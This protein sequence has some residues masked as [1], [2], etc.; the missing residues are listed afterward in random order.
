MLRE[1]GDRLGKAL[2]NRD[3]GLRAGRPPPQPSH[4]TIEEPPG[5]GTDVVEELERGVGSF[6]VDGAC[7][8]EDLQ[9]AVDLFRRGE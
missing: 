2:G 5:E 1:E 8:E 4:S 9:V 3:G 6:G 7:P